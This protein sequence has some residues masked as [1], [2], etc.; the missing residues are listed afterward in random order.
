MAL[1]SLI[2][3]TDI[4]MT[5]TPGKAGDRS[6]G[7]APVQPKTKTIKTGTI[8]KARDKAEQDEFFALACVRESDLTDDDE[9][10]EGLDL[11]KAEKAEK[12]KAAKETKAAKSDD[13]D[14]GKTLV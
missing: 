6:K 11:K 7:I 10:D 9:D 5:V 3:I 8:F 13:D 1:K 4:E 2:A 14:D 12:A